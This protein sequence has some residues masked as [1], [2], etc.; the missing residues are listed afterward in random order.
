MK[1]DTLHIAYIITKLELG[2][3][4]KVCLSLFQDI[5]KKG[6][7]TFLFSG[8]QGT[9][10]PEV[11]THENVVLLSCLVREIGI[12]SFV[13]ELR[14]FFTLITKLRALKKK[15]PQLMVHTHSTKAGILGRWA[16]LFAG[17]KTRIHTIHGYAFHPHQFSLIWY[18]IYMVELLTSFITTHYICV[19]SADVAQGVKLFPRFGKKHSI[20]RAATAHQ[21]FI[22]AQKASHAHATSSP[23]IVGTVACFKKQK[24]IIDLIRACA[25]AYQ[26]NSNIRLEIVGDGVLRPDIEQALEKHNIRHITTLHGWQKDVGSVMQNWQLFALSSL[27]EGLPCSIIEAR[28]L[29]LPVVSYDTGGIHDVIIDGENGFLYTQKDWVGLAHGII[30]LSNDAA[31]YHKM[32]TYPDDLRLFD[33]DVM[34]QEHMKLYKSL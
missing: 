9:L 10:V 34:V 33:T 12:K 11:A 5:L 22:P 26:H 18:G 32:A 2:G 29:K 25:Y 24:N 7:S 19:S 21:H 27:W 17:I 28:L 4:Q 8:N 14:A 20:I 3:A 13:S 30:R 16:A 23:W 1:K 6:H 31:L 15:Y